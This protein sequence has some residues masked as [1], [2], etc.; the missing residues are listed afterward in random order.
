L[1]GAYFAIIGRTATPISYRPLAGGAPEQIFGGDQPPEHILACDLSDDGRWLMVTTFAGS[2]GDRTQLHV[3]DLANGRKAIPIATAADAKYVAAASPRRLYVTTTAGAPK[4]RVYEVD[5]L[6]PQRHF[7]K[8]VIPEAPHNLEGVALAGGRLLAS[9]LVDVVSEVRLFETD[10]RHVRDLALPGPG[11]LAGLSASWASDEI[12]YSFESFNHPITRYRSS[13][14]E[15]GAQVFYRDPVPFDPAALMVEQVWFRSKDGT[16]VPMFLLSRKDKAMDGKRP[17][18]M[19]GY[20]GFSVSNTPAFDPVAA[21]WAERGGVFALVNLRGGAEFGDEW[22][23]AGMRER[24]QNVF[25]D[26]IAAAEWLIRRG[27]TIPAKLA[28][29]GGSNGGLLVGAAITQRPDLFR[30]AL[31][32]VPLLDMLRYQNFLIARLW[33]PEYGSAEDPKQFEYLR[34]Y[35]PYHNVKDGTKY[36]AVMFKTGDSDTRVAP[37]HARKMCARLQAASASGF[38]ILLHY[39]KESGHSGGLPVNKRIAD[40]TDEVAFLWGQ[41]GGE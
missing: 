21:A 36:P 25:D 40:A 41:V 1:K 35:S 6:R 10:G 2:A 14:R 32:A 37:L 3:L 16:R 18:L 4:G 34:R 39:D 8:L 15:G 9:Y 19:S 27:V 11:S 7:W 33:T 5:P 29:E 26:F 22:H 24:K 30:A 38:P 12:L 13:A 28:I 23:Q 20:G 31:C 17:V